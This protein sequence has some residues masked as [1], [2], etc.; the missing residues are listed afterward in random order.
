MDNTLV[1]YNALDVFMTICQSMVA[2][3]VF[4]GY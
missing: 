1:L 4:M 2:R 3:R